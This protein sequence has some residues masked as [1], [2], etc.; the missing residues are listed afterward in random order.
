MELDS[1]IRLRPDYLGLEFGPQKI[2][3][4]MELYWAYQANSQILQGKIL[5]VLVNFLNKSFLVPPAMKFKKQKK[6][7][8]K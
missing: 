6:K 2:P 7:K 5:N 3:Y 4:G 1:S 8:S